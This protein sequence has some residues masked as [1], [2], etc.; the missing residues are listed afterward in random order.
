MRLSLIYCEDPYHVWIKW[1]EHGDRCLCG[2]KE[3]LNRANSRLSKNRRTYRIFAF[4]ARPDRIH[5]GH[6]RWRRDY[7]HQ[8]NSFSV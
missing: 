2:E 1:C 4:S 8:M 3:S 6:H 7:L 5:F